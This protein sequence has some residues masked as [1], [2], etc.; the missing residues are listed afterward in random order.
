MNWI[1]TSAISLT[2]LFSGAL[3][4][5]ELRPATEHAWENYLA[6][7]DARM[8][9]RT[10]GTFLWV[11]ESDERLASVRA[12]EIVVAPIQAK[13]PIAVPH[14]LVH[15][16]IGASFIRGAHLEEVKTQLRNYERY[17][18]FYAPTVKGVQVIDRDSDNDQ[19]RDRYVLTVT[20]QSGLW[21]RAIEGEY[22]SN[23]AALDAHRCYAL[24]HSVHVQEW[25]EYGTAQQHKLAPG[26]GSGYIWN[27][28]TISRFDERDGGVYIEVEAIALS[29][30]IPASLHFLVDPIISRV[31]RA[32]LATSLAKTR[33]AIET[34]VELASL[35]NR[36]GG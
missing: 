24:S 2:L 10:H 8:T 17:D 28:A 4:A 6:V 7:A 11:D 12:G 22:T 32:S 29:R 35:K 9:D 19:A 15:H 33:K 31:A 14:G 13:M 16:W 5:A 36:V 3:R 21:K 26:E 18:E 20:S 27:L 30:D 1:S 34:K 23:F 25:S